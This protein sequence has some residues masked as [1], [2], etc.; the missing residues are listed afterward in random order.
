MLIS[1]SYTYS[2]SYSYSYSHTYITIF[3]HI[4]PLFPKHN[5]LARWWLLSCDPGIKN[6]VGFLPARD[7]STGF[8]SLCTDICSTSC[9]VCEICSK[10]ARRTL[11]ES[12]GL[13]RMPG[14]RA[15]VSN[16]SAWPSLLDE[17]AAFSLAES[18]TYATSRG[19]NV[20]GASPLA[21]I[22]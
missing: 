3:T 8:A 14:I 17:K 15:A 6:C 2:Y 10:R 12:C 21:A 20:G 19:R 9:P 7:G 13:A 4:H 11:S 1:Y 18:V 22:A 16:M 5:V